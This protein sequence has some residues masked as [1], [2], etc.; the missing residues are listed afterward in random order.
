MSATNSEIYDANEIGNYRSLSGLA[1]VSALL[2]FASPLYFASPVFS[3]IP[4]TAIALGLLA[5]FR[6][7]SSENSMTGS[8]LAK[9]GLFLSLV[10]LVSPWAQGYSR[11]LSSKSLVASTSRAWLEAVT[12]KDWEQA[13]LLVDK[14]KLYGLLPRSSAPD[15]APP[16]F[17]LDL[18][19]A[20]FAKM[21]Q[22]QEVAAWEIE[23]DFKIDFQQCTFD[24]SERNPVANCVLEMDDKQGQLRRLS[25]SLQRRKLSVSR[26]KWLLV[27]W[28]ELPS[29][30]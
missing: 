16:R 4:V 27:H 3:A 1:V 28:H 7:H 21:E 6:I 18:A 22:T 20:Q 24:W 23:D 17:D 5:L 30:E 13:A 19:T 10:F 14:E 12:A 25:L 8:F 11:D 9:L 2:G 26:A 29:G 15:A